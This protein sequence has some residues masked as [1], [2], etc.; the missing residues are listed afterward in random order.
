MSHYINKYNGSNQTSNNICYKK[1][2]VHIVLDLRMNTPIKKN[3]RANIAPAIKVGRFTAT[4]DDGI[5][6]PI[7]ADAKSILAISANVLAAK[8]I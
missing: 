4:D 7:T 1:P 3:P 2:L 8:S 5:K 6:N